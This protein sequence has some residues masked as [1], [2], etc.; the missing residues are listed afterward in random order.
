MSNEVVIEIIK[1]GVLAQCE[2]AALEEQWTLD[3]T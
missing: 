1:V 2:W 3:I